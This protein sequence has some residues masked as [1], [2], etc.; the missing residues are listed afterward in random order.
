[1]SE[2]GLDPYPTY[3]KK[4]CKITFRGET[5]TNEYM[6][7]SS[8]GPVSQCHVLPHVSTNS[9][10][11]FYACVC[12]R[13]AKDD[14]PNRDWR[15][16]RD[17]IRMAPTLLSQKFGELGKVKHVY[18]LYEWLDRSTYTL[19]EKAEIALAVDTFRGRPID[20]VR[21]VFSRE[22][23]L[24][25]EWYYKINYARGIFPPHALIKGIMGPI[26]SSVEDL[27]YK[28]SKYSIKP[29]APAEKVIRLVNK[30]GNCVVLS[31]SDISKMESAYCKEFLKLVDGTCLKFFLE[32]EYHSEIDAYVRYVTHK[33]KFKEHSKCV[34]F[35]IAC[36]RFSGEITTSWGHF[37]LNILIVY[38]IAYCCNI[39]VEIVAEG[40]DNIVYWYGKPDFGIYEKLG[41]SVKLQTFANIGKASF[42]HV[43]F[44]ELTLSR[45]R[46][47]R[48]ILMKLTYTLS[49]YK[50]TVNQKIRFGLLKAKTLSCLYEFPSCPVISIVAYNLY[51]QVYM[52]EPIFDWNENSY[53]RDLY[54]S[55]PLAINKKPCINEN[56]RLIYS[57]LYLITPESQLILEKASE[58]IRVTD[59]YWPH[60]FDDILF[61]TH[62]Y[63]K[64]WFSLQRYMVPFM[65][66]KGEME[67]T[68]IGN[69]VYFK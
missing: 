18:T 35:V 14:N 8:I 6:V 56:D 42:C 37:M 20:R 67:P 17:F 46:D 66:M 69:R 36:K 68:M 61:S 21:E 47:A 23:F 27:V 12:K 38:Y 63:S 13:I 60:I 5:V 50:N 45:F 24:K 32:S 51:K 7:A 48:E 49:K 9:K 11:N 19:E 54:A 44:N 1:M 58:D 57:E 29:F 33:F 65:A 28:E 39:D 62:E 64:D 15:V 59:L 31:T 3:D 40:D 30:F 10:Q 4:C 43:E 41:L 22:F 55:L 2:V 26:V 16:V 25:A 34:Q 52:Y 53:K